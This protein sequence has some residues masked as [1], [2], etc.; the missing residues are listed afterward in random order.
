MAVRLYSSCSQWGLLFS[1][2]ARSSV[3]GGF[4]C[5]RA[6]ARGHMDFSSWGFRALEHRLN[7]C[8]VGA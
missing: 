6:Q 4:S 3:C 2:S 8:G 7:S 1:C 5:C